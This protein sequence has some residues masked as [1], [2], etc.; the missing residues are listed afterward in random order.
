MRR[1]LICMLH[2]LPINLSFSF[3]LYRSSQLQWLLLLLLLSLITP[4]NHELMLVMNVE[5]DLWETSLLAVWG[6]SLLFSSLFIYLIQVRLLWIVN[7]YV[8]TYSPWYI[9]N[10]SM[11]IYRW[12]L[13]IST[14]NNV[15]SQRQ[16]PPQTNNTITSGQYNPQ[17][18]TPKSPDRNH[19]HV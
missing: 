13:T 14:Q 1:K 19:R 6:S 15:C 17:K 10:D 8:T 7:F 9:L 4:R 11:K 5:P 18:L 16:V 3:L 2:P 12:R